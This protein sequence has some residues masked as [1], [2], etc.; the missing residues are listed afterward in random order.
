LVLIDLSDRELTGKELEAL[1]QQADIST[2]KNTVP[3]E[4]RSPFV[5]SGLRLG[6]PALTTR[7][8]KEDDFEEIGNII[9]DII[10]KRETAIEGSV[11][12]V[13]KICAKYPVTY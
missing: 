9:A 1:L 6:S 11:A 5:T 8:L 12:R 13:K 2:N 4:K 7:G 3:N 10:E